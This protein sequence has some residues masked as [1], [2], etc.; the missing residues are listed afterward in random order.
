MSVASN[1]QQEVDRQLDNDD[2]QAV[3]SYLMQQIRQLSDQ[4]SRLNAEVN[5][6]RSYWQLDANGDLYTKHNLYSQKAIT[7]MKSV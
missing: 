2:A 1:L 6:L 7:A 3:I 5:Q 4:V